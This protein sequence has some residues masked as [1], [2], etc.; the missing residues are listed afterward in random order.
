MKG[1]FYPRV[2]I[3][4]LIDIQRIGIVLSHGKRMFCHTVRDGCFSR[5]V[6]YYSS[7]IG[8]II[9]PAMLDRLLCK[10]AFRGTDGDPAKPIN[11]VHKAKSQYCSWLRMCAAQR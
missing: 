7:Q 8:T 6:D 2:R 5:L 1:F 4:D 10:M 9:F 11:I 3:L